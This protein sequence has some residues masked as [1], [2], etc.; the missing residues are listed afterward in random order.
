MIYERTGLVVEIDVGTDYAATREAMGDGRAHIGW[1]NTFNYVLAHE[2]YGVDVALVT[3]R[4]GETSYVGQINVNAEAGIESLADLE[5]AVM[6]WVDPNSTS[7]YLIPLIILKA[8]GFD[9]DR[10]FA[11]TVM[12]GSHSSVITQVYNGQCDVGATYN[13]ARDSIAGD[14]PD[15]KDRV[16]ILAYTP[17]IPNDC[18]SFVADL[19]VDLR[20]RIVGAL[21]EIA[22]T[23]EGRQTLEDL[24]SISGLQEADDSFY[25]AFR[26]DLSK[27]GMDIEELVE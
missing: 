6:C 9:P 14:F 27:A 18:I 21:L 7:G 13:D 3:V 12:A 17:E 1:L 11:K 25:D 24:Y 8:D 5:G 22:R 10:D 4:Y 26:A 2:K 19:P 23:N 20:E 15:V 16:L